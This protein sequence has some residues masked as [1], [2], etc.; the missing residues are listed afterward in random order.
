MPIPTFPVVGKV[1]VCAKAK[2]TKH[3]ASKEKSNFFIVR[4]F[5]FG[6]PN[7]SEG[8]ALLPFGETERDCLF[9][10]F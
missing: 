2:L 7:H 10:L 8:G 1:L 5:K 4:L 6:L 3:S 9:I